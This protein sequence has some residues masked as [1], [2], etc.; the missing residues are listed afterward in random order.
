[1]LPKA[2]ELVNSMQKNST[3]AGLSLLV[4]MTRAEPSEA[5]SKVLTDKQLAA[6]LFK[7]ISS[8]RANPY[9]KILSSQWYLLVITDQW[10]IAF[11]VCTEANVLAKSTIQGSFPI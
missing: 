4:S 5:V 9:C 2:L 10:Y 11:L 3:E 6:T 7:V 8:S 1:M